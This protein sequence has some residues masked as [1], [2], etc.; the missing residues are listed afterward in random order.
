MAH[1]D[2]DDFLG[3]QATFLPCFKWPQQPVTVLFLGEHL[4]SGVETSGAP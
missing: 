2:K 1:E 3:G 4:A